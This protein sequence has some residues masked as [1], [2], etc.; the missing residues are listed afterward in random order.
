MQKNQRNQKNDRSLFGFSK[1]DKDRQK[2]KDKQRDKEW[3][4]LIWLDEI[5]DDDDD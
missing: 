4:Q 2:E 5:L 3:N 1:P